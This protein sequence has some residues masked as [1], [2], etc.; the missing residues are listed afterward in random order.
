MDFGELLTSKIKPV[1]I[2]RHIRD[3]K[4]GKRK[5]ETDSSKWKATCDECG[6]KKM[7]YD[8]LRY[9]CPNCGYVLEV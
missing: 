6:C 7:E 2:P 9:C 5:F 8:N 4:S 3:F 1:K